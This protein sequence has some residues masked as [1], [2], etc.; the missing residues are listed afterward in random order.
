M[1]LVRDYKT[2][3]K[4]IKK[5]YNVS[6]TIRNLE[7]KTT[8]Y[9]SGNK[10]CNTADKSVFPQVIKSFINNTRVTRARL[11]VKGTIKY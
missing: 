5:S 3:E 2:I 6:G 7:R 9:E 1:N 8:L 11:M 4:K 10:G